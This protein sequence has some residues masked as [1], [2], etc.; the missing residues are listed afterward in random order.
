MIQKR[1][2]VLWGHYPYGAYTGIDHIGQSKIYEP[3]SAPKGHRG[4]GPFLGKAH[5]YIIITGAKNYARYIFHASP[6]YLDN[7]AIPS[8]QVIQVTNQ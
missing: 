2:V 1:P 8:I 7:A 3:V 5:Q 4:N 6:P